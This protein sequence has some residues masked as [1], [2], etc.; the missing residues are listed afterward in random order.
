[1]AQFFPE[2]F[3]QE[4][5][6]RNN[7]E[8]VISAYTPLKRAGS[9]L[10]G[11]CPF[12]REKTPSFSVSTDK[13]LYHCFGCGASGTVLNFIMNIENLDFVEAV[14][15]LADRAGMDIPETTY[16]K[17]HSRELTQ[18]L[19]NVNK[20][21]ALYF[22]KMLFTE[23]GKE[24]LEYVKSRQLSPE[25]VKHFAL[26]FAP[27]NGGLVK[28]LI[29]LGYDED[30]ILRAGLTASTDSGRIY[31][32]FINR[33]MFPII[34][35]RKNVIGFG[36]RVLDDSKPKY[37]N[38]SETPV[39]N[40]SRNLF[41]LNFAKDAKTD[42]FLLVEG[43][44]D[45]IS[46]H[47]SGITSAVATL[48]T[49]LTEEQAKI[50]KRSKSE[51]VISYDTDEAGQKATKRA[52]EILAETGLTVKVL[53]QKDCK[54]PD[55]Y[56]KKFGAGAF[57]KLIEEAPVQIEYKISKLKDKYNLSVAQDK[58]DYIKEL[59]AELAKFE[60]AVEREIYAK[61]TAAEASVS[62]S[63]I[64]S[65]IDRIIN[66]NER[67]KRGARV[68]SR[69]DTTGK[70]IKKPDSE[71]TL[72]AIICNDLALCEKVKQQVKP[73][74]FSVDVYKEI[75]EKLYNGI[76]PKS[77]MTNPIYSDVLAEILF[78]DM[79]F[80]NMDISLSELI[81][82]ILLENNKRLQ[83]KAIAEGDMQLLNELIKESRRIDS[84]GEQ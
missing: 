57:V 13:Q 59:A 12:H 24:A 75:A 31:E 69:P 51:V 18:T 81:N 28:H 17:G 22:H 77:L 71:K 1:M 65:E 82:G 48:G 47:Q 33:L 37:L 21:A 52:I 72:L 15:L 27:K 20:D 68:F 29:S 19:H 53:T 44:M 4:V 61:E 49:A 74:C 8:D 23:E 64:L 2:N 5:I 73:D 35:K 78:G 40:K 38:T 41:A 7:I 39:F 60:S 67:K 30:T 83:D 58:I 14:K 56:V 32:R 45:V 16:E 46:L 54:D 9:N 10:K 26:G 84:N 6:Y 3:I 62:E 63:A 36:G 42:Y 66:E 11:L 70:V 79:K 43:Y 50:I 34:D 80:D 25:T 76:E 55:E